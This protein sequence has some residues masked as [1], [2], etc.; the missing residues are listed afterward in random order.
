[1]VSLIFDVRH[2]HRHDRYRHRHDRRHRH[3]CRS[4]YDRLCYC[5]LARSFHYRHRQI[6]PRLEK[7][8]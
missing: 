7:R 2:R 6:L 3:D 4:Y 1:M 5:W 8:N